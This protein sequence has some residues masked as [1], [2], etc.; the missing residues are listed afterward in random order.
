MKNSIKTIISKLYKNTITKDSFIKK[1]EQ[2]QEK[3]VDELYIKKLIEK[4]IEN[5][6]ASDIEE[7]VV[8]I[9]SDNFDNYEYIKEL[10][11]ILLESWHFKHED[12]VRILQDLKDPSTI[13]CLHKVAEMHFDYLDYDD[14]YQLARKSIKALSAIDNVDAINKLYILSNSKISI[15]SE[16]AKKEL[17]NKGL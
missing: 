15:I 16:Y 2:E 7:A 12:I 3:D 17:K 6:S 14:T 4:G 8:L 10:C 1:Y 13:D 9:Y 11:D 5:K